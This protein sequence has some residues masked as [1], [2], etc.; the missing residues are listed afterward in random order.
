MSGR[1]LLPPSTCQHAYLLPNHFPD[2]TPFPFSLRQDSNSSLPGQNS[3]SPFALPLRQDITSSSP[4]LFLSAR[5]VTPLPLCLTSSPG[6]QFL[7]TLPFHLCQ[8]SN[9]YSPIA[10]PLHQDSN[11]FLS[12]QQLLLTHRLSSL[13]GK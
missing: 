5:T 1:Q 8:D 3:F 12:G 10:F 13:P 2:L 4:S 9:T 11:T 7:L 6:Q